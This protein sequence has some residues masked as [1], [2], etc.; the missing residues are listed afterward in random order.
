MPL[1]HHALMGQQKWKVAVNIYL[2][3]DVRQQLRESSFRL[4]ISAS[5]LVEMLLR[6]HLAELE[7]EIL[8]KSSLA[9]S[10]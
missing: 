6:G 9:G 5:V 4:R 1:C 8:R 3:D 2:P 7:K 10:R